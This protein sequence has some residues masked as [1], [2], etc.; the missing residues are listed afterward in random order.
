MESKRQ[1]NIAYR[2]PVCGVSTLGVAGDF[3]RR[4]NIIRFRCSCE[5][6]PTLDLTLAADDKVRLNVPCLLCKDSHSFVLPRATYLTKEEINLSCPFSGIDILHIGDAEK[7]EAALKRTEGE[8]SRLLAAFGADE[9]S[10]IQPRDMNDDEILPDPAVYDT[11]RLV[12]KDIEAEG[13]IECMCNA[14]EYDLRFAEGGVECYC[15]RC[16]SKYLF[17]ATTQTMAEEYL[18][19]DRLK[20]S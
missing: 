11:L 10:D 9:L 15:T 8:I 5:D 2:C 17:S 19:L 1:R 20:L 3:A 7:V 4:D 14:G 12:V 18:S 13:G 16:G 6:A